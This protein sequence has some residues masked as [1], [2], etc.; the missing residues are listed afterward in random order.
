MECISQGTASS[1]QGL[2]IKYCYLPLFRIYCSIPTKFLF[3]TFGLYR[4]SDF[5][6]NNYIYRD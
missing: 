1:W 3:R 5:K 6:N 4:L 2:L